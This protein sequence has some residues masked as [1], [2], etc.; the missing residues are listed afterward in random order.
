MALHFKGTG[1]II[2]QHLLAY[3]NKITLTNRDIKHPAQINPI[4]CSAFPPPL[5][6]IHY[7]LSILIFNFFQ[8]R[9]W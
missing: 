2:S 5:S 4:F 7:P 3:A 6:I 8:N 1:I 9:F